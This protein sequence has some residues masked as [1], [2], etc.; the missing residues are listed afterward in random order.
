M[1]WD[2]NPSSHQKHSYYPQ[3]Y[4]HHLLGMVQSESIPVIHVVLINLL[5]KRKQLPL[6]QNYFMQITVNK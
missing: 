2:F 5:E 3:L 1:A 6:L 4:I